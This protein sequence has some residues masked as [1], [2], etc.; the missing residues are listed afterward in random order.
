MS[1]ADELAVPPPL[2]NATTIPRQIEQRHS[3]ANRL[4]IMVFGACFGTVLLACGIAYLAMERT[5]YHAEDQ[6]LRQRAQTALDWLESGPY[7]EALLYH[8]ITENTSE[9]REIYLRLFNEKGSFTIE[10]PDMDK[11]VPMSLFPP[12]HDLALGEVKA[13]TLYNDKGEA[14]RSLVMRVK[15]GGAINETEL[16]VQASSNTSLDDE[17]I[18]WFGELLLAVLIAGM[19]ICFLLARSISRRGLE[20]LKRIAMATQG[21]DAQ[22]LDY[23]LNRERLPREISELAGEINGMLGRLE[24]T[25]AGLRHYADNVAHELRG[26]INKMLLEADTILNRERAD[27]TYRDAL[28]ANAEEARHL[29]RIISSILFLARAESGAMDI[30]KESF[31]IRKELLRVAEFFEASAEEEGI[32]V[33]V[34]CPED[35]VLQGD[36]VLIQRAVSNLVGN[37]ISHGKLGGHILIRAETDRSQIVIHVI[38]D[39]E[40]IPADKI[41]HVFERF[42][43]ADGVRTSGS[44]LGLGLPIAKSILAL[45]GGTICLDSVAG[46]GTHIILTLPKA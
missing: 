26:P 20:P 33:S 13:I 40:G 38:D 21:L 3:L 1:F 4:T 45:H 37:S 32:E 12:S 24:L 17:A 18:R 44:R 7:D 36:R 6:V 28:E 29:A 2:P 43:R 22:R 11:R 14:F 31:F 41:P 15:G 25:Y 9:P 5:L 39:G 34:E 46:E 30:T 19:V 23:R 8:E 16:I 27:E 35:L 10:T 42:Y